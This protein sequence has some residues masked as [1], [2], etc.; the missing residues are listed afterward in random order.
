MGWGGGDDRFGALFLQTGDLT[1]RNQ[2]RFDISV[3]LVSARTRNVYVT[4]A[5]GNS[6]IERSLYLI[7]LVDWASLY[8]SELKQGDPIEIK[9]I[10]YLKDELSKL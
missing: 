8:L 2:R 1:Q 9:V 10:D 4:Q 6:Q 3:E 5:K 7:H